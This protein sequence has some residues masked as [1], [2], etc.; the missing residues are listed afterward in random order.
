MTIEEAKQVLVLY[1]PNTADQED[2]DFVEALRLC[3][4]DAAL[5]DWFEEHCSIYQSIR[6]KLKQ[7][8]VPEGLAE[9]IIAEKKIK[10]SNFWDV[11]LAK[12]AL[13]GIAAVAAICFLTL[14]WL[15]AR[16]DTG[17]SG[18]RDR[19]LSTALRNYAM[20]FSTQK[21]ADARAFLS[22]HG[23][24][25]DFEI[26]PALKDTEL[27]GCVATTWQ[28]KPVSMICFRSK[29]PFNPQKTSD[30]WLFVTD[31]SSVRNMPTTAKPLV[32]ELQSWNVTTA[33]WIENGKAYLL[34][35]EGEKELLK[36][37]F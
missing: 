30:L 12:T 24:I 28:G 10:P 27:V 22:Q 2:P 15:P 32:E 13:A 4:E 8:A 5:R 9:Q 6:R 31:I 33:S 23:A 14:Q 18:F 35:I 11:P 34:A 20:D 7:V 1:R 26:P 25:G 16:E 17:F 19:M 37:Y 29:H 36:Q 3:E 21:M